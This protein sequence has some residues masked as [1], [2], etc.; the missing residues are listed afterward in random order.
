MLSQLP[1]EADIDSVNIISVSSRALANPH[2]F[3]EVLNSVLYTDATTQVQQ[4]SLNA[5]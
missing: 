3:S 1:Q 4:C 5:V 2:D